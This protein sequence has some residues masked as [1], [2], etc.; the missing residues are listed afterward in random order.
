MN[1][2]STIIFFGA[3]AILQASW[4]VAD[5]TDMLGVSWIN[6]EDQPLLFSCDVWASDIWESEL[7]GGDIMSTS[8]RENGLK[9]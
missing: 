9:Q 1:L 2:T 6:D 4:R 8:W 7:S 5:I 3:A